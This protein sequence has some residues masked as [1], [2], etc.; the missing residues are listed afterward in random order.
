MNLEHYLGLIE[1]PVMGIV[2]WPMV[3][4]GRDIDDLPPIFIEE[5]E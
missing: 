5:G 4:G 2:E 1:N 3:I